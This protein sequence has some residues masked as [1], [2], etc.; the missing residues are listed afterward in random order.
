MSH[1]RTSFSGASGGEGGAKLGAPVNISP[2]PAR[3]LSGVS[4][5]ETDLLGLQRPGGG[6]TPKNSP[7][8]IKADAG[9]TDTSD[10]RDSTTGFLAAGEE[11]E[12]PR[13]GS[14]SHS[15]MR[16]TDEELEMASKTRSFASDATL[17]LADQTLSLTVVDRHM[18]ID[19][20]E[21]VEEEV[22]ERR[23]P[24]GSSRVG[25]ALEETDP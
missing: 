10:R 14:H 20:E 6:E 21:D 9:S 25:E 18:G 4:S 11:A 3:R 12:K 19:D 1:S 24:R 17:K 13:Q 5:S 8:R 15:I 16:I 23:R 2:R 22:Q 7:V